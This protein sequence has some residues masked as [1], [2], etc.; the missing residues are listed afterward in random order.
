M[1]VYQRDRSRHVTL[2]G[3]STA[4]SQRP[5]PN[6]DPNEEPQA[7]ARVSAARQ[8]FQEVAASKVSRPPL[9]RRCSVPQVSLSH[10]SSLSRSLSFPG[11]STCSIVCI[12]TP[13]SFSCQAV[14]SSSTHHAP[15]TTHFEPLTLHLSL[16]RLSLLHSY[17]APLATL[18]ILLSSTSPTPLN[19]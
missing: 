16:L 10:S 12:V 17:L 14:S 13:S 11:P 19:S 5:F 4:S 3:E 1:A 8:V 18:C 15:R 6:E 9:T 2:R 7:S